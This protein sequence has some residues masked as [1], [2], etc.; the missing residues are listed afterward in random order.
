M[1]SCIICVLTT[2]FHPFPW[3]SI[4]TLFPRPV[5]KV[6][7]NTHFYPPYSY[8]LSTYCNLSFKLPITNFT[9]TDYTL[10]FPI[11]ISLPLVQNEFVYTKDTILWYKHDEKQV[12][13]WNIPSESWYTSDD[14]PYR[15]ILF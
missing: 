12:N 5:H 14:Y 10:L 15:S 6:Y 2:L 9:G 11:T 3:T 4:S 7:F 13:I 8:F 1:V